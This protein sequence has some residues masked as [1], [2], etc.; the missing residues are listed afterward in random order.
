M[1]AMMSI[2]YSILILCK[3]TVLSPQNMLGDRDGLGRSQ[4]RQLILALVNRFRGLSKGEDFW[5][6]ALRVGNLVPWLDEQMDNVQGKV[7]GSVALPHPIDGPRAEEE[8]SS[9][10]DTTLMTGGDPYY[11]SPSTA[12][13]PMPSSGYIGELA[14][15]PTTPF[16]PAFGQ[17]GTSSSS[18]SNGMAGGPMDVRWEEAVW[19]QMLAVY[20]NMFSYD[21][22]PN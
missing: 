19:Q 13:G 22:R 7:A 5:Q 17:N 1:T 6:L 18:S 2:W 20:P 16:Q 8:A 12:E 4:V 14:G 11:A 10:A 3:L 15:I 9:P 21:Y